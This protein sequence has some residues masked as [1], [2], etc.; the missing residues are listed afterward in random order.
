MSQVQILSF[1]PKGIVA[2]K[3]L[4]AQFYCGAQELCDFTISS[5]EGVATSNP[6]LSIRVSLIVADK[7]LRQLA[8]GGLRLKKN[9]C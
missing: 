9:S 5:T 1:R 6:D 4:Q 2:S 7:P 3:A 8:L